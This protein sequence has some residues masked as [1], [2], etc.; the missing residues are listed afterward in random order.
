MK[1]AS[2]A[3]LLARLPIAMSMFGHGLVRI[4]KLEKFSAGM[5]KEF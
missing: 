3:Y 1:N 2:A 5:V 4:P